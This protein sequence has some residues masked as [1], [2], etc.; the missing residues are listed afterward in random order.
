MQ[1]MRQFV[2]VFLLAFSLPFGL[3]AAA[4]LHYLP[5]IPVLQTSSLTID[6]NESL[7]VLNLS[8]NAKQIL[9]FSIEAIQGQS[10]APAA[11]PA[12]VFFSFKDI[13]V[14]LRV[15][16][17]QTTFDPRADKGAV[18]LMQLSRIISRPFCL[19]INQEGCLVP[20]PQQ[21][22]SVFK[23]FPALKEIDLE[24]LINEL[25]YHMFALMG[26]DLEVGKIFTQKPAWKVLNAFP[27]EISYKILRITDKEIVAEI[28]G[29]TAPFEKVFNGTSKKEGQKPMS[30]GM[31][32]S[33]V[34]K[35]EISWGRS[36]A[37]L[38]DLQTE[39]ISTAK[40]KSGD[41]EW[42]MNVNIAHK[43]T[44]GNL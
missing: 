15:N 23:E 12:G 6:V 16:R 7:P 31:I 39:Y 14:D 27:A 33:G 28:N 18:P 1:K 26:K 38:Y 22:K 4:R 44:T 34:L 24:S 37:M 17:E 30:V 5:G 13:F 21:I 40:L 2:I 32:A 9:K 19:S 43:A 36:N 41:M 8:S 3:H 11:A 29:V 42:T 20:D 10:Q 35:G 25:L